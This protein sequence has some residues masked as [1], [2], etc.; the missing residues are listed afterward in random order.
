MT[1]AL[2]SQP[3]RLPAEDT[4]F[5]FGAAQAG[6]A[7]GDAKGQYELAICYGKGLGVAGQGGMGVS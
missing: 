6:A 1:L 2:W 4:N 7:K 3:L 5:N